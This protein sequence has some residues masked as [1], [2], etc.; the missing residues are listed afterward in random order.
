MNSRVLFEDLDSGR[1]SE[2]VLVYP[3]E[4][5]IAAMRVSILSAVGTA[6]LG[7]RAGQ[8]IAWEL[9]SGKVGRYRVLSVVYQPEAAGD[10]HL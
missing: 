4:A 2:V 7:L 5:D 9:P 6:L 1:R 3:H 10:F 8:N